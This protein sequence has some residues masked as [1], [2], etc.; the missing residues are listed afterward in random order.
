MDDILTSF[1]SVQGSLSPAMVTDL[2]ERTISHK[3][4][5]SF[6]EIYQVIA[7]EVSSRHDLQ[8]DLVS[9]WLQLLYIFTYGT[10]Q[11][12][13]TKSSIKLEDPARKKLKQLTLASMASKSSRLKFESLIEE[14][15]IERSELEKFIVETMYDGLITGKINT[16][17]EYVDIRHVQG[18]DPDPARLANIAEILHQTTTKTQAIINET[19]EYIKHSKSEAAAQEQLSQAYKKQ[20][21]SLSWEGA[22]NKVVF[23]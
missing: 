17:L 8:V 11:E 16:K 5:Y 23:S 12:Y 18:R 7:H 1:N 22:A 20:V 13:T 9:S 6:A 19:S 10:W 14:L 2:I 3:G 21:E 4:L 15:E